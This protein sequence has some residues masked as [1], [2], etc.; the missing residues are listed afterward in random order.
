MKN[1]IWLGVIIYDT[2]E[3]IINIISLFKEDNDEDC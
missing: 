3:S 1:L 2:I